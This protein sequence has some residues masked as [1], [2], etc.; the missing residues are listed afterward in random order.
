MLL[1]RHSGSHVPLEMEIREYTVLALQVAVWHIVKIR[2]S[3]TVVG[4][5]NSTGRA[6]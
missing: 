4:G 1:V 6:K 3:K 5:M 2:Q